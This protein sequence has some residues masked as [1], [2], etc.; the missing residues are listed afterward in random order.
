MNSLPFRNHEAVTHL[1][2]GLKLLLCAYI[3]ICI[4][5]ASFLPVMLV[6]MKSVFSAVCKKIGHFKEL[7]LELKFVFLFIKL[8][9]EQ[10]F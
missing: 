4:M 7:H 10:K 5:S 8:I 9:F 3:Q 2:M 1:R 6:T